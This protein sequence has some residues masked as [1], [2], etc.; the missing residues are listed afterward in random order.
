M[1]QAKLRKSIGNE[2]ERALEKVDIKAIAWALERLAS[3]ASDKFGSDCYLHAAL[4]Q[5]ML[6]DMGVPTEIVG[7][8]AGW[9]V[10]PGDGDVITHL[11]VKGPLPPGAHPYHA[12][13]RCGRY[14]IDF[15]T[16]QLPIKAASLDQ[17]DG[18]TTQVDWAPKYLL[19]L[20]ESCHT[21][22]E[23]QQE[24]AGMYFYTRDIPTESLIKRNAHPVDE[25]DVQNLKLLFQN[26]DMVAILI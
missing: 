20:A 8:Y 2:A 12:W 18:G 17:M 15:T 19:V 16:Y 9:R 22:H 3:A 6:A 11:P 14:L 5:R 1:G 7:G 21:F 25:Q 24:R 10:G 13:L 26:P 23:V 4:G